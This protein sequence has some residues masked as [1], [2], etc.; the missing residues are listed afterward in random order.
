M[1]AAMLRLSQWIN[2]GTPPPSGQP[3]DVVGGAIQRDSLGIAL[4]GIRTSGNGCAD[5]DA[6]G[7]WQ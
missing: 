5:V 1:D 6:T 7:Y 2:G 3:I 4:D